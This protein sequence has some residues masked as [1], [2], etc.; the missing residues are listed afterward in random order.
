[1]LCSYFTVF[2][3]TYNVGSILPVF[4]V[5]KKIGL[6]VEKEGFRWGREGDCEL[7]YPAATG[8]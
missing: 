4:A 6:Q 3:G 7:G 2:S 5:K 8:N 1:M